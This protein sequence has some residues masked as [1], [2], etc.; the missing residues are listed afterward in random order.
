MVMRELKIWRAVGELEEVRRMSETMTWQV[1]GLGEL[2]QRW[3]G[4]RSSEEMEVLGFEE[5]EESDWRVK[6]EVREMM[7]RVG[8]ERVIMRRALLVHGELGEVILLVGGER[9]GSEVEAMVDKGLQGEG[10]KLIV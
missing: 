6:R 5:E 9:S 8:R 10:L 3:E 7:M 2:V 4:W 1:E